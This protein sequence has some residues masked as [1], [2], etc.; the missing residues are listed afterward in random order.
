DTPAS[1]LITKSTDDA[2]RSAI[3]FA[4]DQPRSRGEFVGNGLY[5]GFQ[6]VS[7]RV[8]AS[9]IVAQRLHSGDA[10]REIHK[11][12][13][14]GTAKAVSNDHGNR[15]AGTLLKLASQC[16]G[17]TIRVSRKQHSML[18]PVDVRNIDAAIRAKKSMLRL[19]N[20][21]AILT[22]NHAATLA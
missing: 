10:D 8:A 3:Q 9:A 19:S 21:H 15:N 5:A 11:P 22:T 13:A 20:Q 12:F 1:G 14:P 2:R 17:R 18:A 6:L 16:S 4:A 7:P